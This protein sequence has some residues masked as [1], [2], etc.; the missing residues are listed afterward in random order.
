MHKAPGK[1]RVDIIVNNDMVETR[2]ID[3][4]LSGHLDGNGADTL[5]PC[6]TIDMVESW[7]VK[8]SLF[9]QLARGGECVDLSAIP[10]ASAKFNF[11]SQRLLLSIP[12]AAINQQ[13]RDY[14]P[15]EQ[16]DEGINALLLKLYRQRCQ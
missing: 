4:R 6:L 11:Y 12:L 7:G 3:F 1:Y 9:P 2:E 5:Q 13:V 16:W 15:P 10:M 14:V 8:T